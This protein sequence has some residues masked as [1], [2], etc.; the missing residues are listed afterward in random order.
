MSKLIISRFLWE[1]YTEIGLMLVFSLLI[2][3]F[4]LIML[5]FDKFINLCISGKD[6]S[7]YLFYFQN[8]N[9]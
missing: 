7:W 3:L 6:T 2:F 9:K 1:Q 8:I 5:A 4:N